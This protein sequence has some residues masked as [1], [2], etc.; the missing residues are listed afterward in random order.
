MHL[1]P[2]PPVLNAPGA[3][4]LSGS[5]P[6]AAGGSGW[7]GGGFRDA[8]G[9]G[10]G[11]ARPRRRS[12]DGSFSR[13]VG[14]CA[15]CGPTNGGG[16]AGGGG[17][18]PSRGAADEVTGRAAPRGGGC[19]RRGPTRP[20]PMGR[21]TRLQQPPPLP[22]GGSH[23]HP[24]PPQH[25]GRGCFCR[26]LPVWRCSGTGVGGC[27]GGSNAECGGCSPPPSRRQMRMSYA[28]LRHAGAR[29]QTTEVRTKS[30][31]VTLPSPPYLKRPPVFLLREA[32]RS[33]SK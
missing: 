26:F 6:C 15:V 5:W 31:S 28:E 19:R 30:P 32:P 8:L 2:P 11:S 16:G 25:R 10:L 20:R 13:H 29:R 22:P 21:H 1:L 33:A 27:G 23:V 9:G 17:A 12:G 3:A 18:S 4:D 24:P 14:R 7:G